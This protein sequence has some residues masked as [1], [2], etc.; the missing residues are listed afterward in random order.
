MENKEKYL[1]AIVDVNGDCMKLDIKSYPCV[2]RQKNIKCPLYLSG[3][4]YQAHFE[5]KLR[6]EE[7]LKELRGLK[8]DGK[9]NE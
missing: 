2:N 3:C 9:S 8:E 5:V 7:S 4:E 1:E 6:A